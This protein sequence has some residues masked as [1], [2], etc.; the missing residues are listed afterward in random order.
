MRFAVATL[1]HTYPGA[2]TEVKAHWGSPEAHEELN[3]MLL[4]RRF[5]G[6]A[7]TLRRDDPDVL[8]KLNPGAVLHTWTHRRRDR[9]ATRPK[10]AVEN[11]LVS[12]PQPALYGAKT[13]VRTKDLI[14]PSTTT[15]PDWW[16]G[17]VAAL[18]GAELGA[19]DVVDLFTGEPITALDGMLA[20]P[21]L[22]VTTS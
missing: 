5:D 10:A 14:G 3:G 2:D 6:F 21:T 4:A 22:E 12:T 9:G 13:E 15:K 1:P 18:L 19:D 8:T 20:F 17:W 7:I 11:L 16:H